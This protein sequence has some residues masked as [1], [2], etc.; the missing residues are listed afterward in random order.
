MT[1]LRTAAQMALDA[2][3]SEDIVCSGCTGGSVGNMCCREQQWD[4]AKAIRAMEDKE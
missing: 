4:A 1:D 2:L 3:T